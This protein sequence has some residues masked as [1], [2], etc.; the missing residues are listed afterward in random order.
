MPTLVIEKVAPAHPDYAV[1]PLWAFLE[2]DGI[3]TFVAVERM[4]HLEEPGIRPPPLKADLEPLEQVLLDNNTKL[5]EAYGKL[6]NS[7][8]RVGIPYSDK[9]FWYPWVAL[10]AHA[11]T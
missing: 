4:R 10:I 3:K 7:D 8:K 5:P 2:E 6:L 9:E 11:P 1:I